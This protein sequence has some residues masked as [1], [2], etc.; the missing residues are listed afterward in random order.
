MM[1]GQLRFDG[2]TFKPRQDS[3]RLT[4]QWWDVWLLMCDGQWRTLRMISDLTGHPEASVSA[5]LRD[6]RKPRFGRH[7]VER[8]YIA[9][10][11]HEYRVVRNEN[12]LVIDGSV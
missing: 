1:D 7:E 11:L 9:Q 10:G 6:F 2:D 12:V 8:R 5:R 4:K 3:V